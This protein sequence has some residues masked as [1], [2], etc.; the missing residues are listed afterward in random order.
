[1]T[2]PPIPEHGLS[3]RGF[4]RGVAGGTAAVAVAAVLPAGCAPAYPEQRAD[5]APL[6][7]LTPKEYAVAR[8]AADAMLVDVPVAPEAVA[9][10]IDTE[11]AVAGD[12]MRTDMKTVL[13]LMEHG[14]LLSFRGRRFSALSADARRAVLEDWATSRLNLRRAAFQALK[15]FVVFFAYIDDSTRGLTGFPGPWPERVRIPAYE[16]D[17]G[18]IG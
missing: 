5:G 6:R 8:A 16:V 10:A 14:T 18:E 12:P 17:F 7:S 15:G 1:M 9:S 3:R 4:L 2:I 11:L 13:S